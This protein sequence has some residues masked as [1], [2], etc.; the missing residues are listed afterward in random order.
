MKS[1]DAAEFERVA[2]AT[3]AR[4]KLLRELR[5][6]LDE[7]SDWDERE[8]VCATDRTRDKGVL[9]IEIDGKRYAAPYE[10]TRR[11]VDKAT[12]RS[13]SVT[14]DLCYTWRSGGDAARIRFVRTSD[15]HTIT[16]LCC[17]DLA[18]SA[19][20][21]G[22]TSAAKISRANLREDLTN[23]QRIERLRSKLRALADT[24]GLS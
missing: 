5:F 3:G 12:G 10:L 11:V 16:W 1:I 13:K 9:L 15:K 6:A 23:E 8:F 2:K 4:S 20:V 7:I 17:A 18:C 22:K 19:H 24:L 14:C 21:R